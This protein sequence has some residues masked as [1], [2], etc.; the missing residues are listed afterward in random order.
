MNKKN[1]KNN[2]VETKKSYNNPVSSI[3]G[4]IAIV[5]LCVAMVGG[6]LASL[7]YAIVSNFGNV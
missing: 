1:K 6:I 2:K 5:F 7:I 4:K 3:W